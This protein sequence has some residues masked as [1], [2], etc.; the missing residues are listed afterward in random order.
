[1]LIDQIIRHLSSVRDQLL[2]GK[3]NIDSTL[4]QVEVAQIEQ[5]KLR[6][7]QAYKDAGYKITNNPTTPEQQ[8]F[9]NLYYWYNR[10][11]KDPNASKKK[12]GRPRNIDR[13]YY[14][15]IQNLY[16]EAA[17]MTA[18]V[19]PTVDPISKRELESPPFILELVS[20][21]IPPVFPNNNVA[22]MLTDKMCDESELDISKATEITNMSSITEVLNNEKEYIKTSPMRI[23]PGDMIFC[24][25]IIRKREKC[26]EQMPAS[27]IKKLTEIYEKISKDNDYPDLVD[28]KYIKAL[29]SLLGY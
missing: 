1:M 2:I 14:G 13:S 23:K 17:A 7:Y 22:S 24:D 20:S 21:D 18:S 16:S 26:N 3:Q 9:R 25:S 4:T 8:E 10:T 28:V 5:V 11:F 6:R 27:L 15:K 19:T 29:K 12:R